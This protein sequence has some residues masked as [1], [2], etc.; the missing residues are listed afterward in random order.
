MGKVRLLRFLGPYGEMRVHLRL[1]EGI[2][3]EEGG[4]GAGVWLRGY[5]ASYPV[6]ERRS[7][8]DVMTGAGKS[9]LVAS[10]L[11]QGLNRLRKSSSPATV[12][13]GRGF[14]RAVKANE[15][16]GL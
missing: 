14:I 9:G 11:E 2:D 12:L 7:R 5:F 16:C 15:M 1:T 8:P 4:R 10:Q 6:H 13:K 3:G